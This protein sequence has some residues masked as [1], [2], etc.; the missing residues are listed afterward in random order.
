VLPP[1][2]RG[3]IGIV[4]AR[5]DV[6]NGVPLDYKIPKHWVGIFYAY[7]DRFR[8]TLAK[9]GSTAL[10]PNPSGRSKR[11]DTISEETTNLIQKEL[12]IR[13]NAHIF[14]HLAARLYL[15]AH[16]GDYEGLRRLLA[17]LSG[18]ATFVFYEGGEMRSAVNRYDALLE[19]MIG[20]V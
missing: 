13:W 2:R 5:K 3:E 9:N 7:L 17:H 15:R 16:P 4:I 8:P 18:E 10:F 11:P 20:P 14:R 1:H 19:S 6:K 12:G